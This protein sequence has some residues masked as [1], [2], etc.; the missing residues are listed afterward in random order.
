MGNAQ[1]NH[2][3]SKAVTTVA[4]EMGNALDWGTKTF[5]P[6]L[7]PAAKTLQKGWSDSKDYIHSIDKDKKA[8][9]GKESSVQAFR[10]KT[11]NSPFAIY[12]GKDL[13]QNTAQA[14]VNDDRFKKKVGEYSQQMF[15]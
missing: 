13:V 3:A 8:L 12:D 11:K 4:N 1:S 14:A 7:N 9:P 5:L 10:D 6:F 2:D 15:S